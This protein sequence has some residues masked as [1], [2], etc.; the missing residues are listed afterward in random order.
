M[1]LHEEGIYMGEI[2]HW[3]LGQTQNGTPFLEFSILVTAEEHPDGS[4]QKVEKPFTAPVPLYLSSKARE[5]SITTLKY[6]GFTDTDPRK[7]DRKHPKAHNF[8]GLPVH[9]RCNIEE[10][11]G[12]ENNKWQFSRRPR[13]A[14]GK[15]LDSIFAGLLEGFETEMNRANGKVP[16]CS[17]FSFV[18][19]EDMVT[20]SF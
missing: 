9:V 3:F 5:N 7:L 18:P 13:P 15:E 14:Q 2:Q 1:P 8:A 11:N 4:T 19:S 17:D 6:L 20:G 12:R 10:Y 16:D